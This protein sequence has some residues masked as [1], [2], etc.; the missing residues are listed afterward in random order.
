MRSK[1]VRLLTVPLVT[2][3]L[4][5]PVATADILEL[6]DGRLLDG[7]YKGGTQG[8]LRFQSDGKLLVFQVREVIALTFTGDTASSPVVGTSTDAGGA[9]APANTAT[10]KG[11]SVP[12]GTQLLVRLS[13][14]VGTHNMSAGDRF[15]AKLESKLMS[16]S[17]V[18]A[19]AGS[20][21][22]GEVVRSS[23][24][25]IGSRK[26]A[27]ELTLTQIKIDGELKPI[28]TSV[29]RGEGEKGG[30]GRK[31]LKGAAVGAL[32]DGSDGAET[33]AR[34]GAGVGILAGGK[35]AGIRSGTLLGFVLE[36]PLGL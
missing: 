22:Y 7:Q 32:A 3:P 21:V 4:L 24:G 9:P 18:V 29:F 19:P 30:L 16:G 23:K 33:G 31:L 13:E 10:N 15:S 25:G 20:T 35:H 6:R 1:L 28:S 8:T 17:V 34:I 14:E 36:S 2:F 5:G 27:L 12:A 11:Q 26:A